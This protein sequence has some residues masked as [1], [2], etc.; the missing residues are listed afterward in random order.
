[1]VRL[2]IFS[3]EAGEGLSEQIKALRENDIFYT[4][5]RNVNGTNVLKFTP[6]EAKE[7]K[8]ALKAEGIGVSCIGSPLGKRD[9]CSF[10][11][12]KADLDKIIE[13]AKIFESDK[14][15]LFSF[16]NFLGKEDMVIDCLSRA[17]EYAK[18]HGIKLY[19]ENELG[20]YGDSPRACR[21]IVDNTGCECIFDPANFVLSGHDIAEAEALLLP[22][23]DFY[24][25]KDG[26]YSGEIVP[27]GYGDG[28]LKSL[29]SHDG[30]TLTVEPHLFEF[31]GLANLVDH[32]LKQS[33]FSYATPRLAFD[34][35]VTA[36]KAILDQNGISYR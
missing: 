20:I 22:V 1:M 8:R 25:I 34:A 28:N 23:S 16:Y 18:P 12:F 19:H 27:A 10:E 5:I 4:D 7:Y 3:D 33:E 24:H 15:R 13:L 29:L 9:A 6:K 14:I 17:V 2:S 21:Y 35:G 36:V 31:G 30:V 11:E 26:R 32:G